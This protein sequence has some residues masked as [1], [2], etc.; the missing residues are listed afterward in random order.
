MVLGKNIRS[1]TKHLG[2]FE[3][4]IIRSL[5]HFFGL[6]GYE[7]VPHAS[8]NIAWGSILSDIDLLLVKDGLLTY[9]EVKSRRDNLAKAIVQIEKVKDYFDYAFIA[10]DRQIGDLD[11]SNIGLISVKGDK[12]KLIAKA[13]RFK[14]KPTFSSLISLKKKCLVKFVG[15]G[16]ARPTHVSKYEL[17][18]YVHEV[19]TSECTRKCLREIVTCGDTCDTHC[20]ITKFVN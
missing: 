10:T 17:A 13:G 2:S 7:V 11:T 1:S 4:K 6:K 14:N 16:G 19:R 15:N 18:R 5:V 8:L 20:P 12:A 3:S 9:V